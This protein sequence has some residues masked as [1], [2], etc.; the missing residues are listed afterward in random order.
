MLHADLKILEQVAGFS[1]LFVP[2]NQQAV[3]FIILELTLTV[4]RPTE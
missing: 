2:L 4:S 3:N 1:P